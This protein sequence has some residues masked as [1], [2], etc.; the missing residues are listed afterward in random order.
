[1][2]NKY[3]NCADLKNYLPCLLLMLFE[4]ADKETRV[5]KRPPCN[6]KGNTPEN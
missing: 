4:G 6:Y 1:M 3:E 5:P 2:E